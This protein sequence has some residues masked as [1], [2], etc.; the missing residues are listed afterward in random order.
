MANF[1]E[2]F[3]D[4]PNVGYCSSSEDEVD[5]EA[6]NSL[7]MPL[8]EGSNTG[9]KGVI[10][11]YKAHQREI[12][13]KLHEKELAVLK[14]A[15]RM[16]LEK[17]VNQD[18][19]DEDELEQIRQ[20]RLLHMRVSIRGRIN[21]LKTK[22]E[23]L[24][25]SEDPLNLNFIYIYESANDAQVLHDALLEISSSCRN[26]KFFRI[27]SSILETSKKFTSKA[28]PTLQIYQNGELLGNFVKIF[29]TLG[30]DFSTE[31][32]VAF[33]KK[34]HITIDG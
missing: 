28:L 21:E 23:F 2:K 8:N 24:T 26:A 33:L 29:D 20:R 19:D 13:R 5:V 12:R 17:P 11:D 1:D 10:E 32:L 22:E 16:T 9:P 30:E 14:E 25:A 6:S 31:E 4:G 27:K 3:L 7:E 18:D 34:K 15:G